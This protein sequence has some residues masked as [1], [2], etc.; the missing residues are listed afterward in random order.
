MSNNDE[1]KRFS[2]VKGPDRMELMS[3]FTLRNQV[4]FEL[5]DGST[6]NVIIN[7]ISFES[8]DCHSWLLTGYVVSW[9][10]NKQPCATF[11]GFYRTHPKYHKE[12][13]IGPTLGHL[14]IT[15]HSPPKI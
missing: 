11:E 5:G 13:T 9:G 8:A 3:N 4:L 15:H 2:I 14:D 10:P 12:N 1:S 7:G 6:I